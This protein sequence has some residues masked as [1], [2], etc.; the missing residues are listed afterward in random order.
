MEIKWK[1]I[2][3]FKGHTAHSNCNKYSIYLFII[4][5]QFVIILFGEKKT[6]CKNIRRYN[7][8]LCKKLYIM[9]MSRPGEWF[10]S[11]NSYI[12]KS[13]VTHKLNAIRILMELRSGYV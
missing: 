1:A 8:S 11:S 5:L 4:F 10:L 12:Y 3:K 2:S 13:I 6:I 9:G 7:R